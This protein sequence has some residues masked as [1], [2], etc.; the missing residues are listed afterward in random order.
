FILLAV[1]FG[2]GLIFSIIA[3]LFGASPVISIFLG[4]L[5]TV[6]GLS[7]LFDSYKTAKKFNQ[8]N[9]ATVPVVKKQPFLAVF[10]SLWLPGLGQIYNSQ[11]GKAIG[12]MVLCFLAP[13]FLGAL[14]KP[15]GVVIAHI[16][17]PVIK[18]FVLNDAYSSA[19]KI[20]GGNGN[21]FS[22][23]HKNIINGVI[24]LWL[25][26]LIFSAVSTV[27]LRTFFISPYKYPTQSMSPA[28]QP[29]DKI[30][31]NKW[32]YRH[33]NP[34]RGDLVVFQS[35]AAP[36][37]DLLKR[38]AGLPGEK[39]KIQDG[40]IYINDKLLETP[41]FPRERQYFNIEEWQYGKGG[42][43]IQIPQNSYF[44][45]GDNSAKSA[46]SRQFGFV[47]RKVIKAKAFFIW[48][49]PHRRGKLK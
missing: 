39:L 19:D 46:D 35:P 13:S 12:C 47:P 41:E 4:L 3:V 16:I 40:H 22:R 10:L 42:L 27:T 11:I 36:K 8:E 49:P 31:V 43:V 17:D 26:P 6:L 7:I 30:F 1:G 28:L 25:F 45:L 21:V 14:L 24:L 48:W 23:F 34:K 37:K 9:N 32:I 29:G 5:G 18:L 44:V 33:E 2:V 20:N 38:V 15:L